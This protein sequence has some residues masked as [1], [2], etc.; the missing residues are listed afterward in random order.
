MPRSSPVAPSTL[1]VVIPTRHRPQLACAAITSVVQQAGER[2]TVV[3]SDNSDRAEDR[4]IIAAFAAHQ[5]PRVVTYVQ[6]PGRLAMSAH[7]DW[8]LRRAIEKNPASHYT[9]LTD[10]MVFRPGFLPELLDIAD[11]HPGDIVSY[12]YDKVEDTT[13]VIHL[14]LE[15]WSGRLLA[16]DAGH[17]LS[18]A[19]RGILSHALPRMLNTMVPR[20]ILDAVRARFGTVFAS[21]SPDVCFAFRSLA[22]VDRLLYYDKAGLIQYAIGRSQG[23]NYQRGLKAP[24]V[25]D[26][27]ALL[28]G[29][30]LELNAAPIPQFK[31]MVNSVFHEYAFVK[32]QAG[33]PKFP[34]I[35]RDAYLGVI[36]LDLLNMW[37]RR[38]AAAVRHQLRAHGWSELKTAGRF[39]QKAAQWIVH[40]PGRL[41]E[42]LLRPVRQ[43]R[44]FATSEEAIAWAI[45]HPRRSTSSLSHQ[46]QLR[47]R[48][49]DDHETAGRNAD[50]EALL[51]A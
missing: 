41:T 40:D 51:S 45:A 31:T 6:A 5:D 36:A 13:P 38:R 15:R 50:E 2:I 9:Y 16:I 20:Q 23:I 7:W 48:P 33:S 29:S 46:W 43:R 49:L 28:G 8:A 3:V 42:M 47:P 24:E 22:I 37:D 11:R 30:S 12:N 35:D 32:A 1:A 14:E 26:F 19:S 18:C 10:R 25:A 44:H 34:E 4:Q 17:I 27:A 39:L 21:I